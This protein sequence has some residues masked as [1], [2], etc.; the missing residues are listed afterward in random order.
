MIDEIEGATMKQLQSVL[1]SAVFRLH[2]SLHFHF[3]IHSE[4]LFLENLNFDMTFNW[5]LLKHAFKKLS[6]LT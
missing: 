6:P 3:D 2:I 1:L 4:Y 5:P